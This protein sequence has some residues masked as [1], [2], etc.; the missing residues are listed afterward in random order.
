MISFKL[1]NEENAK[2]QVSLCA[3]E[4]GQDA[5]SSF[6][7]IID[8]LESCDDV[9]YAAS[10]A[11]GCALIRVFDMGR[12]FFLYPYELVEDASISSAIDSITEYA[13]REEVPMVF[14]DV[15]SDATSSF[16]GFRHI[17]MDAEDRRCESYRIRIKTECELASEIPSVKWGR[18]TL[19]ALEDADAT[20]LAILSKDENVNKYWGYN[21]SDDVSNPDDGWFLENARAEF[22]SGS[23]MSMAIRV[24]G[25]FVGE[26]VLYAFDG[27]GAAEFAL[28]LLPKWQGAGIGTETARALIL[29]AKEIGL[30][31]LRARVMKENAPSCAMLHK[32]LDS[33]TENER[34]LIFRIEI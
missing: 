1:L 32:V 22:A 29:V 13:M 26:A 20:D 31:E 17:D 19:S 11:H 3:A 23:S 14:S 30:T 21:Y 34:E 5:A 7:D 27:R 25:G 4:L 2:E 6:A 9:E 8:S 12:Y 28:R 18:V 10:I 15:P 33:F 16:A 24:G